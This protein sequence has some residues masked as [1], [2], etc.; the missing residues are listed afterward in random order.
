MFK[1]VYPE[2]I[3]NLLISPPPP[4]IILWF[5]A[6]FLDQANNIQN[7]INYIDILI[8]PFFYIALYFIR[9]S[10]YV[11]AGIVFLVLYIEYVDAAYIARG[12]AISIL[13]IIFLAIW[14]ERPQL[15]TSMVIGSLQL[16]RA[17]V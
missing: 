5:S 14:Y 12:A 1:I 13:L 9:R 3:L 8:T 2:L 7:L 6:R 4:N 16:G 15:I 10:I 17:H 11:L